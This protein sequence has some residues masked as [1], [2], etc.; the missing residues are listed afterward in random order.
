MCICRKQ[1]QLNEA[2]PVGAQ[3]GSRI[4]QSPKK[5]RY[6]WNFHSGWGGVGGNQFPTFDA[7]F[8]FTK[9]QNTRVEG[10]WGGG[11]VG[12]NQFST[13]DAEFKFAKIQNSHVPWGGGRVGGNNFQLLMLS[14]NL[15]KSKIPMSG[16]GGGGGGWLV[17]PI[18]NFWCWVQIC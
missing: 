18:S 17:E 12:G 11:G 6:I 8:K 1:C 9:I 5:V 10:G 16:G 15:L 4:Y 14:S 13:F 3:S 2:P 7:E